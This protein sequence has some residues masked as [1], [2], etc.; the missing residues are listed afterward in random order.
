[1]QR[2]IVSIKSGNVGGRN[3]KTISNWVEIVNE[4]LPKRAP[5]QKQ[6]LYCVCN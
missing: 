2:N 4:P 1:M 6:K 3:L 5:K